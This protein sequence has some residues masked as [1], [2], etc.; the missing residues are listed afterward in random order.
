MEEL[1]KGLDRK[2]PEELYND[3]YKELYKEH[4]EPLKELETRLESQ[5]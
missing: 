1:R 3:P 4:K 5:C 2:E